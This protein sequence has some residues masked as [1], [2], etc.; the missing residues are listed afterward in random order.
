MG[1]EFEN[2]VRERS[3][4]ID[5]IHLL[6]QS[7]SLFSI[8][9]DDPVFIA[10]YDRDKIFN[11]LNILDTTEE[12][13][14]KKEKENNTHLEEIF[15]LFGVSEV[16]A[17]EELKANGLKS[18]KAKYPATIDDEILNILNSPNTVE[19]LKTGEL[20]NIPNR[21]Y[22]LLHLKYYRDLY[23]D[24]WQSPASYLRKVYA[25]GKSFMGYGYAVDVLKK[26][27]IL[28]RS[29]GKYTDFNP[30]LKA[31]RAIK[32][33]HCKNKFTLLKLAEN[34]LSAKC[35][36][37]SFKT[38]LNGNWQFLCPICQGP[39]EQEKFDNKEYDPTC[40]VAS[41]IFGEESF[42]VMI[43]K[44]FRNQFLCRYYL[45]KKFISFYYNF[46]PILSRKI[47]R[48]AHAKNVIKV[49]IIVTVRIFLKLSKKRED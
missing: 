24:S 3:F 14:S 4:L 2:Y 16:A 44:N 34:I 45:G 49:L 43:L 30:D 23:Y 11:C 48:L 15:Y 25:L 36:L 39:L 41:V 12:A 5:Q 35:I 22:K 28:S 38:Y 42:E 8:E 26:I 46:G 31:D 47:K 29:V 19:A 9:S 32:C 10:T 27:T 21:L 6:R 37:H 17:I 33:S 18:A 20:K 1:K 40:F 13:L 7:Y